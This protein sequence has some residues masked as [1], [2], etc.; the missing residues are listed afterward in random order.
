MRGLSLYPGL[1]HMPNLKQILMKL[2]VQLRP[3]RLLVQL[4][5]TRL[6]LFLKK[7][8][9]KDTAVVNLED[10]GVRADNIPAGKELVSINFPE[11]QEIKD[12]ASAVFL[13]TGKNVLLDSN[14]RG[15]IQIISSRMVTKEE[16]YQAFLSA[17]NMLDLTTVEA[18]KVIKDHAHT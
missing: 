11:P 16:A 9:P 12:I 13:W 14:V 3:I 7:K 4:R 8:T 10:M 15:K 2:L 1:F 5:Q 18:G 6:L 17:L